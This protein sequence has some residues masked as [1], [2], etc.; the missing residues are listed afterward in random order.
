MAR[1]ADLCNNNICVTLYFDNNEP[2][3]NKH[4]LILL[5]TLS[6]NSQEPKLKIVFEILRV[7]F[8]KISVF[9]SAWPKSWIWQTLGHVRNILC[10]W[11]N[12][13]WISKK[14]FDWKTSFEALWRWPFPKNI[15][16]ILQGQLNSGFMSVRVDNWNFLKN[17][18]NDFKNSFQ[19]G[20]LWLPSK[21]GEQN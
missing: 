17:D 2:S 6:R 3:K 9:Y 16:N 10:K 7:L 14:S 12:K 15:P 21:T 4:F 5:S 8:K 13:F 11:Q 19:F 1:N 18:S 20:F